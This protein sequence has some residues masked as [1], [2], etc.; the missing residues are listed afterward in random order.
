VAPWA[1]ARL[2]AILATALARAPDARFQSAESFGAA[3]ET[4]ARRNDLIATSAEVGA[5]VR[6]LFAEPLAERRAEVRRLAAETTASP[7][8]TPIP[9]GLDRRPSGAPIHDPAAATATRRYDRPSDAAGVEASGLLRK[10]QRDPGA[11]GEPPSARASQPSPASVDEPELKIPTSSG[12]LWKGALVLAVLAAAGGAIAFVATRFGGDTRRDAH[13]PSPSAATV[14]APAPTPPPSAP[15]AATPAPPPSGL[16]AS[17]VASPALSASS[18]KLS[19]KMPKG[20]G[21]HAPS[22]YP[23]T[24]GVP[25]SAWPPA[26]P[27]PPPAPPPDDPSGL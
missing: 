12:A 8:A 10:G 23:I 6:E 7:R 24:T 15:A 11:T 2:D 21:S 9:A 22:S 14:A 17:P 4:A 18:R 26:A 25:L 3:L 27:A 19:G 16:A 20:A 13:P 5:F 1:H